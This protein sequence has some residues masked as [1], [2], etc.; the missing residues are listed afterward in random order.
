MKNFIYWGFFLIIFCSLGKA[1]DGVRVPGERD[2]RAG[3]HVPQPDRAVVVPREEEVAERRVVQ[4]GELRAIL[5]QHGE[6]R[7]FVRVPHADGVV[8]RRRVDQRRVAR[9]AAADDD[10]DF[11]VVRRA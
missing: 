3:V 2:G 7:H 8:E 5:A 4:A 10:L 6:R 11:V 9:R 1:A